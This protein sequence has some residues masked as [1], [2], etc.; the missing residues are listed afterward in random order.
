MSNNFNTH[1]LFIHIP[2]NAGTSLK[3]ILLEHNF[4]L[5]GHNINF[6]WINTNNLKT[7]IVIRDPVSRFISS[8]NYSICNAQNE[9]LSENILQ[10]IRCPDDW[11]EAML[12]SDHDLYK[13]VWDT[14]I[15]NKLNRIH[16]LDDRIL[17]YRWHWSHQYLWIKNP[18]YVIIYEKLYEEITLLLNSLSNKPVDLVLPKMNQSFGS[19]YISD[20]NRQKIYDFYNKDL[21]L[22][23]T[24]KH[25]SVNI[26]LNLVSKNVF[27]NIFDNNTL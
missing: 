20:L 21:D 7:L 11:A 10:H 1:I 4:I 14:I 27:D 13:D 5:A 2:K 26:R 9:G 25:M 23:N 3:K 17:K 19:D 15:N 22:Y 6:N 24:Y 16:T 18:T 12:N 8:V